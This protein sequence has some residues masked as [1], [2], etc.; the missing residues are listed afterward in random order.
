M[1]AAYWKGV[2]LWEALQDFPDA[3]A[4][5]GGEL[6][7]EGVRQDWKLPNPQ[8]ANA[9]RPLEVRC[10]VEE[11]TADAAAGY[12]TGTA[13]Q[14]TLHDVERLLIANWT[15]PGPLCYCENHERKAAISGNE[16]AGANIVVNHG[17]PGGGWTPAVGEKVLFRKKT[18]GEGFT[19]AIEAVGA[20]TVTCDLESALT[21]DWEMVRVERILTEVVY[22]SMGRSP[23]RGADD[24]ERD[25]PEVTYRLRGY[26][27]AEYATASVLAHDAS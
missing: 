5:R 25:V 8:S 21:S 18:T 24:P 2:R 9:S 10:V 22:L 6:E 11:R 13:L 1:R 3:F 14:N 23:A 16:A 17:T 4:E 20:G 7:H 15:T 19:S 27:A 12:E 26:G